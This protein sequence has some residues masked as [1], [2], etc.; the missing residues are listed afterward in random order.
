MWC[1]GNSSREAKRKPSCGSSPGPVCS[2]GQP[3]HGRSPAQESS[4]NFKPSNRVDQGREDHSDRFP[5]LIT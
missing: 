2:A 4:D 3:E 5:Q 1:G